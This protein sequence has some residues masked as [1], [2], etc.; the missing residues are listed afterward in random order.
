M[1]RGA[2]GMD[3]LRGDVNDLEDSGYQ[4]KLSRAERQEADEP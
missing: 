2:L 1:E 4:H 3:A